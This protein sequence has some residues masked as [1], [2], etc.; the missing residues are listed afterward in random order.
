MRSRVVLKPRSFT[1]KPLVTPAVHTEPVQWSV[2]W[3]SSWR[4]HSAPEIDVAD[5]STRARVASG[6]WK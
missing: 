6:R 5:E 2:F 4:R 1:S 3:R